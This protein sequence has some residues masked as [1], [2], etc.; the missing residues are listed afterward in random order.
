MVKKK[1][2]AQKVSSTLTSTKKI[3]LF[4]MSNFVEMPAETPGMYG[5]TRQQQFLL[6]RTIQP[7]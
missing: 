7:D 4:N 3:G 6:G 1:Y 2:S 5:F